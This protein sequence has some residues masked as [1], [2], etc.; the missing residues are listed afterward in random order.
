MYV[1][2]LWSIEKHVSDYLGMEKERVNQEYANL[3]NPTKYMCDLEINFTEDLLKLIKSYQGKVK[4]ITT[5][6][7]QEIKEEKNESSR[8]DR[9]IS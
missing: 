2:N 3:D 6:I 4:D 8:T 9:K 1:V 7:F 5:V